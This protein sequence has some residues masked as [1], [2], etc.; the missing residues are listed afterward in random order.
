M[1]AP[2]PA[3]TPTQQW[4]PATDDAPIPVPFATWPMRALALLLD[5]GL[6]AGVAFLADGGPGF[7]GPTLHPG[8]PT[9][10]TP[11]PETVNASGWVL[12]TL[13]LMALLQAY[14]GATP[15][16]WLVGIVVV[17]TSTGRPAGALR[18]ALRTAAHLLDSILL[19]GYLRPLV[20]RE[21]RTFADSIA[22][23]YVLGTRRPLT[24]PWVAWLADPR[25][26]PL[27]PTGP[28]PPWE[29]PFEPRWRRV[30][31]AVVTSAGVLGVAYGCAPP[32]QTMS[33]TG[34]LTCRPVSS[35]VTGSTTDPTLTEAQVTAS[36]PAEWTRL[37]V[38]RVD[39]VA[40]RLDVTWQL[41]DY[42]ADDESFAA[43]H[44][45]WWATVRDADG[46]L[47]Q[48]VR[49]SSA[50]AVEGLAGATYT[51]GAV[52]ATVPWEAV[53]A[54]DGLDVGDW[55]LEAGQTRDGRTVASCSSP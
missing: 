24:L 40:P 35:D 9:F 3:P 49:V 50:Q 46:T 7:D 17:R 54:V 26:A 55:T 53:E 5:G 19:I 32:T 47:L 6:L 30:V 39:H 34:T 20:N 21:R 38:T 48:T 45:S 29:E 33:G 8:L 11:A 12:G 28:P 25:G 15:G 4:D 27:E 1:S 36:L 42:A 23:T 52:T 51:G 18:T 43:D 41:T 10:T 31:G 22:G 2:P 14:L 44:G 16:K 13:V 37:G